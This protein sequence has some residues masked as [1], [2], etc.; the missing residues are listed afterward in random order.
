MKKNN[1]RSLR[2][3]LIIIAAAALIVIGIQPILIGLFAERLALT[4]SQQGW[5]LSSDMTGILLGTLLLPVLERRCAGRYLYFCAAL[6]AALVNAYCVA[7]DDFATL[8]ACRCACGLSAGLLYAGA[9]N[10]L[11]RLPGQDRS[12]GLVL[13][14]QTA[15]F[16]LVAATLPRLANAAGEQWAILCIGLW[17]SLLVLLSL[18]LPRSLERSTLR[19]Q[20]GTGTALI[21]RYSLLGMLCLQVAIYCLW[22]FIDQLGRERGIDAVDI[23]W[24]FG[25]G[26]LGGLPGAALP[27]LLGARVRRGLMISLGSLLVLL[28]IILLA[29][30]AHTASQLCTALFIMN[31][32]WVLALTYYMASITRNDPHGNLTPLIS[33]VQSGSA[34]LAPAMVAVALPWT[35]HQAIFV[36]SGIAVLTGS[37]LTYLSALP[38]RQ[39]EA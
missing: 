32:G 20:T 31:F 26:V 36:I 27:S 13:L 37:G 1:S 19:Q 33:I 38:G 12:Y 3:T 15:L 22:G 28:S 17:F 18:L 14:I 29:G 35:G 2:A 34:A 9:I 25:L 6:A 23:G 7:V 11:G 8:L 4:L 5:L 24:A 16:A 30:N 10:A 39:R 21:G